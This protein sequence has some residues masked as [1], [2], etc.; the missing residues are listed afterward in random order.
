MFL[1]RL[2]EGTVTY[3]CVGAKD[4]LCGCAGPIIAL[5]LASELP[6]EQIQDL[7]IRAS[8]TAVAQS[9]ATDAT[10]HKAFYISGNTPSVTAAECRFLFEE[11]DL[12][13][14]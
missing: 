11:H 1:N 4:V 14:V 8:E 5:E 7:V 2:Q 6:V 13:K 9:G 12:A 10:T 3:G